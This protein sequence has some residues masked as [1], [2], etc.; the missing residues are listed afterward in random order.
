MDFLAT[1]DDVVAG[2]DNAVRRHDHAGAQRADHP[3][4]WHVETKLVAEELPKERI[5]RKRRDGCCDLHM[6]LGEDIDHRG[7]DTLHHRRK[8][9]LDLRGRGGND[10]GSQR[11][12]RDVDHRRDRLRPRR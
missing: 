3:L 4:S 10:D 8:R 6:V 12:N 2:D 7:R 11:R 1:F 5:V 9:H